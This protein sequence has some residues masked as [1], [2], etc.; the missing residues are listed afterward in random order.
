ME[1]RDLAGA[2]GRG[3]ERYLKWERIIDDRAHEV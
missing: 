2:R 1:A 3:R